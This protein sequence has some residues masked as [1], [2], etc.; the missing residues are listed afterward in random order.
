MMYGKYHNKWRV[1]LISFLSVLLL[2]GVTQSQ[3]GPGKGGGGPPADKGGGPP[4]GKG[5]GGGHETTAGNN[6][7][8]PV[9]FPELLYQKPLPLRGDDLGLV[10]PF[11]FLTLQSEYEAGWYEQGVEANVWQAESYPSP[12]DVTPPGKIIV[13]MIDWGDNLESVNWNLRSPIRVETVLY[14]QQETQ[15][16]PAM[17]GYQMK[18]LYGTERDEVFAT[19]GDTVPPLIE[20]DTDDDGVLDDS[21]PFATVYTDLARISIQKIAELQD[22]DLPDLQWSE[23][24]HYWVTGTGPPSP[25]SIIFS[26]AVYEGAGQDGPGFYSAEVNG[27]GKVI[28]GY[29]WQTK[30]P[31]QN[32]GTGIYRLTF[33]LD[34]SSAAPRPNTYFDSETQIYR[35]VEIE[36]E[37]DGTNEG[38]TAFVKVGTDSQGKNYELTYINIRV[39]AK[40][41]GGGGGKK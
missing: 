12:S 1:V 31:D 5:G 13:D 6:L 22:P 17:E 19:N 32:A 11:D 27:A 21:L 9:V 26:G 18:S 14:V 3:M 30:K 7:S 4:P 35:P 2:A 38:G 15:G 20:V 25:A 28:F 8:W 23:A 16:V 39:E 33:S 10:P 37:S 41:G 34:Q 36:G 40:P 29:N 24:D